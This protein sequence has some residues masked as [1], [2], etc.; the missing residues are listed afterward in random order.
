[1]ITWKPWRLKPKRFALGGKEYVEKL[2]KSWRTDPEDIYYVEKLGIKVP[3][4]QWP[5]HQGDQ[6]FYWN[7]IKRATY[8]AHSICLD[9]SFNFG[10]FCLLIIIFCISCSSVKVHHMA[11]IFSCMLYNVSLH[12]SDI[13]S[14][15][16]SISCVSFLSYSSYLSTCAAISKYLLVT[17]FKDIQASELC[18]SD[19]SLQWSVRALLICKP[20]NY[21][22]KKARA[23]AAYWVTCTLLLS[24]VDRNLW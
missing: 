18:I 13:W 9:I 5:V 2:I 1:M 6:E 10:I 8:K 24:A 12:M 17:T 7:F 3:H 21:Y 4:L 19:P 11:Y 23:C 22:I 15:Y 16:L 14:I 20:T